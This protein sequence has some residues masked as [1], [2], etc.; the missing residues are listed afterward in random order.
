MTSQN[1]YAPVIAPFGVDYSIASLRND[2]YFNGTYYYGVVIHRQH[3]DVCYVN[4]VMLQQFKL[5][6]GK[7]NEKN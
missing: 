6:H 3:L 5:S 1:V 2:V 7:V 4:R